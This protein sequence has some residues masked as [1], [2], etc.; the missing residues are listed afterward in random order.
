MEP[1][2]MAYAELRRIVEQGRHL[3]VGQP[4]QLHGHASYDG[5]EHAA[6]GN[7]EELENAAYRRSGNNQ[8]NDLMIHDIPRRFSL[9]GIA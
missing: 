1:T 4:Q 8:H 2:H 7:V 6:A 9:L 3:N 5:A